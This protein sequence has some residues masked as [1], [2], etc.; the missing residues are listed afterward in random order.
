[1]RKL[2]ISLLSLTCAAVMSAQTFTGSW[3][4]FPSYSTPNKI[5]ET[6]EYVYTLTGASISGTALA[7]GSLAYYDKTTGEVG[8]L[9]TTNRLNGNKVYNIWYAPQ[10]KCLFV[11]F[12]D[13]NIDLLYDDGRTI[14]VPDLRDA[15]I[16]DDKQIN[17]VAF[18]HGNAYIALN[19]GM[20]IIDMDH[21]A[22][23]ESALWGK[24]IGNI[25]AS[26]K[27]LFIRIGNQMYFGNQAGSHHNFD[28]SFAPVGPVWNR[29]L[30]NVMYLGNN[31]IY[32]VDGSKG[33][34]FEVLEDKDIFDTPFRFS[35]LDNHPGISTV[36]LITPTKNGAMTYNGT[37]LNYV[38][39]NGEYT[40][41]TLSAANGNKVADWTGDG[42]APWLADAGGFGKYSAAGTSRVKPKSTSGSNVGRIIQHPL[43]NEFYISTAEVHQN[44]TVSSLSWTKP[45]FADIYIPYTKQFLSIRNDLL[46]KSLMGFN[47]NPNDS[48]VLL[49]GG[50]DQSI[51]LIDKTNWSVIDYNSTNSLL[52]NNSCPMSIYIDKS[53]N[54]W[55]YNTTGGRALVKATKGNWETNPTQNGW[56]KKVFPEINYS[57]S[58]RMVIDEFHNIAIA[59]GKNGISAIQ[60]PDADKPLT[61]SCKS[62]FI[63]TSYDSD[64]SSLGGYKYP[65]LAIDK[66]GWVWIGNDLGVMYI[67]D[68]REMFNTG[69]AVTRPKVARN[70]GTNLADYLLNQVEVMCIAVDE[71]NQKWI[72]TMGSGLYRVNEDGTEILEHLTTENSD[73]PSN[74]ILAVCPDRNSNDVYIGTASGLSIYHSTTSP[75]AEDYSNVYAYPNPVTPDY[76]GYISIVG[77]KANS[78]IKIADASGN[79]FYETMSNGGMALW[80]GCD[81]TG[82]RVRSGVYFVFASQS[83]EEASGAAVTKI[84]VI[85]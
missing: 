5:I 82:K 34:I 21:G 64:G 65:A 49:I 50:Y 47:I 20:I 77:L 24:N 66:N 39:S 15:A 29:K 68:S 58:A 6:P 3:E 4:L 46:K 36:G 30:C 63:D 38:N 13:Y 60:L 69:F 22:V 7:G 78:L 54:L 61:S 9:N 83:G 41:I 32:G 1:M 79:I 72:G 40:K 57:H 55:I 81:A 43:T 42:S 73:I 80:N 48:N 75:A 14:S 74:D 23:T 85:N 10:E 71:N 25:A 37:T 2:I 84:V 45:T 8:S 51:R 16:S 62:V 56:S 70:D 67:K 31:K 17:D 28:N 18:A 33:Y 11:F 52:A 76:T 19:S 53:G 12:E 27:K 35:T 59:T 26:D 44:S